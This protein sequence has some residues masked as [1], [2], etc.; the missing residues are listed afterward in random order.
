MTRSVLTASMLGQ[1]LFATYSSPKKPNSF[2]VG[3]YVEADETHIM[4]QS[5]T[6]T[7]KADGIIVLRFEDIHRF[8]TKSKYL[9]T[10][11]KLI[12]L[13]EKQAKVLP[14][15]TGACMDDALNH[16]KETQRIITVCLKDR[17]CPLISGFV[18]DI[19]NDIITLSVIDQYGEAD[20]ETSFY[21]EDCC[22]LSC[23]SEEET[24]LEKLYT[25]R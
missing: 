23:M 9:M 6:E 8:E 22:L 16:A 20:G 11:E 15:L 14:C 19:H 24:R 17:S 1:Q 4:M 18:A 5:Y 10:L 3:C 13:Q 7:G 2:E 12:Q 21:M 25:I